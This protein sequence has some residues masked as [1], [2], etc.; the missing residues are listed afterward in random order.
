ML[1]IGAA[2]ALSPLV[3][4]HYF[5]LLLVVVALARPALG[6]VWLVPLLMVGSPGTGTPTT[7]E[8]AVA[9]LAA[10]LTLGLALRTPAAR[11]PSVVE[12]THQQAAARS[13]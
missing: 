6:L 13:A 2:L 1:T 8:A 3:W 9:L 10:A 12:T 11:L 5:A 4:L 7:T